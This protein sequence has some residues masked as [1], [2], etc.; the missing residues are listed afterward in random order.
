MSAAFFEVKACM[1][2][3]S[4]AY[5]DLGNLPF[6]L[7]SE[8][9]GANIWKIPHPDYWNKMGRWA[10][11]W[12]SLCCPLVIKIPKDDLRH[13]GHTRDF[14]KLQLKTLLPGHQNPG[15]TRAL[16]DSSDSRYIFNNIW[17]VYVPLIFMIFSPQS[18]IQNPR[19]PNFSFYLLG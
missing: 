3:V 10:C 9:W 6:Q 5:M 11:K 18:G 12:I 19:Q 13:H 16:F 15:H 4:C 2:T 8:W 14:E 17:K 7:V 1:L